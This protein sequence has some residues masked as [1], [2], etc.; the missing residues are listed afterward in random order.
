MKLSPKDQAM[1]ELAT[2]LDAIAPAA[3]AMLAAL[4]EVNSW[5]MQSLDMMPPEIRGAWMRAHAAI[6]QAEAAGIKGDT[7]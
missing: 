4:K 3:R 1:L 2:Q 6:A 5:R 7:L